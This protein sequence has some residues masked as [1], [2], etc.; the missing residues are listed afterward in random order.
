MQDNLNELLSIFEAPLPIYRFEQNNKDKIIDTLNDIFIISK[1]ENPVRDLSIHCRFI[2]LLCTIYNH[3]NENIYM[4][5]TLN[6]PASKIYSITA[7]IHNHYNEDLSLSVLANKFFLSKYY[8]SHLFK[9]VTGFSLTDYIQMTRIRNAQQLLLFTDKKITDIATQCGF[10]SFS[11]FNRAFNKYCKTSPSNYRKK[12]N[13]SFAR[14]S[15][16]SVVYTR[17]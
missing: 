12:G 17:D 13:A 6:T 8:L 11:Q 3:R 14:T 5:E 15:P 16:L 7:Y 4:P 10:S 9:E 2:D 1:S